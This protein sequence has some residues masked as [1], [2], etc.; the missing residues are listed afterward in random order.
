MPTSKYG[1]V[2][3]I[4]GAKLRQKDRDNLRKLAVGF[5]SVGFCVLIPTYGYLPA[6]VIGLFQWL[7]RRIAE[8][9]SAFIR[10]DD[11]LLGHSNGGTLVYLISQRVKVRG[12]VLLNPA[13]EPDMVPDASFIHCYHNN[14]DWMTQLSAMV[15]FHLWGN[16]GTVG[17]I[18]E[19]PRVTNID[20]GNPPAGLPIL[21]GHSDV[22]EHG[23]VRPWSRYMAQLCVDSLITLERRHAGYD[24]D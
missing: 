10:E 23:K 12:A 6:W 21:N 9:M 3:L 15:P 7:D 22:F 24:Q 14:G 5:R 2:V 19:D 13:L 16:M 1:R 4:H 17:Y 18:G 11:I 8:S 20:Q